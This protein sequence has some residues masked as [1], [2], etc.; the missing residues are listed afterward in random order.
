MQFIKYHV[1]FA[2]AL[3]ILKRSSS[4]YAVYKKLY[5]AIAHSAFA[6][7]RAGKFADVPKWEEAGDTCLKTMVRLMTSAHAALTV[8]PAPQSPPG[9]TLN[10]SDEQAYADGVSEAVALVQWCF[11]RRRNELCAAILGSLFD[12]RGV[13]ARVYACYITPSL[14]GVKQFLSQLQE[15][16]QGKGKGQGAGI[17][18]SPF[19]EFAQHAVGMY[20][21]DVLGQPP[22]AA[23]VKRGCEQHRRGGR[24]CISSPARTPRTAKGSKNGSGRARPY[25]FPVRKRSKVAVV[26]KYAWRTRQAAA[27]AFMAGVGTDQEIRELMGD[28]YLDMMRVLVGTGDGFSWDKGWLKTAWYGKA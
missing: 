15:Q 24:R 2:R 16:N 10:S 27:R 4:S 17:A 21:S 14:R 25:A 1:F 18:S 20:L 6:I 26:A 11:L 12:I 23:S 22:L 28:R 13:P 8:R 3:P 5:L 7:R 19:R 9:V